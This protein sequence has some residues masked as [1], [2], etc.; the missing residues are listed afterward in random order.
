MPCVVLGRI[1]YAERQESKWYLKMALPAT[2]GID[3][4]VFRTLLHHAAKVVFVLSTTPPSLNFSQKIYTTIEQQ[5]LAHHKGRLPGGRANSF[6]ASLAFKL[7]VPFEYLGAELFQLGHGAQRQITERS[8]CLSDSAIAAKA[9]ANKYSTALLLSH[10]GLPAPVHRWV[11]SLEEAQMAS[12]ELGWPVVIKPADRE[13]SEGVTVNVR[14]HIEL[15][16]AYA[17]ALKFSRFILVER[18]VSGVCHRILVVDQQF[19]YAMKRQPKSVIGNGQSTIRQLIDVANAAEM[20]KPTW[21]RKKP[22]NLDELALTCLDESGLTPDSI[23]TQGQ[24]IAIR[25]ITSDE[26]GGSA[27]EVTEIIHPDNVK[28]AITAARVLGLKVAGIDLISVDITKPWHQNNAVLN[29]VNFKPFLGGSLENDKVHAYLK[30]I[31][32]GQGRIPV[33]MVAGEGDL[34]LTAQ[35]L[36]TQLALKGIAAY[37]CS[38]TRA[39]CSQG[40]EHHLTSQGLFMRCRAMLRNPDIEGLIIVVDSPEFLTTGLPLDQFDELHWVGSAD[41]TVSKEMIIKLKKAIN[42]K[43]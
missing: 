27:E 17:L 4:T 11:A 36:R 5:V 13:R 1:A 8:A 28:L 21:I 20:N 16:E 40:F 22:W 9:C 30:S 7:K 25:P 6:V 33:H 39:E 26:W 18:H 34:W 37:I 10:A 24:L 2:N 29:E 14:N 42:L 3:P 31:I 41:S 12:T 15:A 43:K 32:T 35:S 23:L 38:Q 19:V